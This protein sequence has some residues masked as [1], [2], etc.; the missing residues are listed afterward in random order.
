MPSAPAKTP[1][2]SVSSVSSVD[3]N[4]AS[5]PAPLEPG[6]PRSEAPGFQLQA[7]NPKSQIANLKSLPS[8]V[9]AQWR[10]A[11]AGMLE[12][13]AFGALLLEVERRLAAAAEPADEPRAVGRPGGSG[14]RGWLAA[15]CPEIPYTSAIRHRDLARA[16][17]GHVGAA[18]EPARLVRALDAPGPGAAPEPEEGELYEE[19]AALVEG[20]SARQL[21]LNFGISSGRGPGRPKGSG[22][23]LSVARPISVAEAERMAE[24]ELEGLVVQ[25]AEFF[26]AH[27]HLKIVE[28]ARRQAIRRNLLD[29]ADLLK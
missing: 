28:P 22:R 24:V 17:A 1:G 29:L 2:R 16:V 20:R 10:R 15:N 21:L 3:K 12:I 26:A 8:A 5:N 6:S 13:V 19:V 11:Q 25:L 14:L 4:H 9:S 23:G 27:K 18:E 7:S